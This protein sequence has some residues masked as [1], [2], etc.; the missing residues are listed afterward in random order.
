M[1]GSPLPKP[2]PRKRTVARKQRQ[3]AAIIQAV[4]AQC[5]DRDGHCRVMRDGAPEQFFGACRGR[6][7]WSH[8]SSHRRSKTMGMAPEDRH[9]RSRS[10]QLCS[11]HSAAYDQHR[12]DIVELSD[13]G[14]DGPL[15]YERD[16][17]VWE[18]A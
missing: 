8:A 11:A 15:R 14:C 5:V 1:T 7:E 6:S 13:A 16:G 10:M 17:A 9:Q 18:G 4:R 12:M 2:E 3:E